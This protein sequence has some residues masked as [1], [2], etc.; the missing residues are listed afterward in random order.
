[1]LCASGV[2]FGEVERREE[3]G[4]GGKAGGRWERTL[5]GFLDFQIVFLRISRL[6]FQGGN[7]SHLLKGRF[8]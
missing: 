6:Y 2:D 8:R 5:P 7:V 3:D 4:R 1:M